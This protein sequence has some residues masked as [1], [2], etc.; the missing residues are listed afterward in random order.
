MPYSPEH[1][2]RTRSNIVRSARR[3]FNRR[4]FS[5][6][7]IDEIMAGAGLTRGGFYAHFKTK[8]ELYAEAVTIFIHDN[9]AQQE[10]TSD[11]EPR[12]EH[13]A[14]TIVNAYLSR[15]HLNNIEESCPLIALP[16]DVARGGQEVKRAFRQVLTM[17]ADVFEANLERS[18][19]PTPHETALAIASLCVGGMTLARAVDDDALG[20]K[21]RDAARTL[22]HQTGAWGAEPLSH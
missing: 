15:E 20:T 6:V 21:I 4:G 5:D 10:K 3:L 18:G 19:H 9:K 11:C 13:L 16:S 22:A 12:G 17:M 8:D 14:R 7:S 1:K 2:A